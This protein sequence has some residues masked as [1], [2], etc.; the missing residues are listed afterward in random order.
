[1]FK[2]IKLA[3]KLFGSFLIVLTL[4]GGLGAYAITQLATVN[5]STVDLATDWMPSVRA[6]LSLKA[7]VNALRVLQF[8]LIVSEDAAAIAED[9]KQIA[10]ETRALIK[11]EDEYAK[12]VS[13]PEE[14][15]VYEAF[16][17]ERTTS[18]P[19]RTRSWPTRA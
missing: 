14:R 3:T 16:R 2:N 17:N 12:L 1:M 6:A 8:R 11:Q 18:S 10:E 13:S 9:E 7:D 5:A 4:M 15:Q 19:N